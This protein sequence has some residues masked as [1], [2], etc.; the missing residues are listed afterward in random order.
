MSSE[1][2]IIQ[3]EEGDASAGT[4]DMHRRGRGGQGFSTGQNTEGKGSQS[5]MA[6]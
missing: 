1:K 2:L 4:A 6:Q 5:E 3:E